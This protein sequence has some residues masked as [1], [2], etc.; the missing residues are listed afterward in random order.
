MTRIKCEILSFLPRTA[1][2]SPTATSPTGTGLYIPESD[3]NTPM[4]NTIPPPTLENKG[5]GVLP[6]LK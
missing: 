4:I 2:T 3:Q 6:N 5:L 1:P